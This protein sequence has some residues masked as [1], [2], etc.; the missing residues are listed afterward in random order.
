LIQLSTRSLRSP[1]NFNLHPKLKRF[2]EKRR[3]LIKGSAQAD[4]A[5]AESLAFGTLLY[6][7]TPVRL[8]GQ[9]SVR[10]TFSQRHLALTDI[11]NGSVYIPLNHISSEQAPLEALDSLLS[12]AAVLGFEYGYSTVDPLALVLWEAQFGDFANVA[13]A[14]IDNFIAVS[15]EKWQLRN[16]IVLLLPHGYEG[17]GPEHSSARIER[18]LTLCAQDNLQVC[19]ITT[20]AQYF[21]LLRRQIKNEVKSPLI[22]FTPKSILRLPEAGS[23]RS[24]FTSGAFLEIIDDEI[25][26]KDSVKRII[27]TGG[28]LYYELIKHRKQSNVNDT[29]IIRIEQLYPY[30]SDML[31]EILSSYTASKK[32]IWVQEEP[33]NMGAWNFL[34]SRLVGDLPVNCLLYYSGRPERASPAVGSS[35][36]SGL[37]QAELIQNS[38]TI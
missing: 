14:M 20:P 6:E 3:E 21:H 23:P 35:R 22:I 5:F 26:L 10:G 28:K 11:H 16:S 24:Q 37:Q 25:L 9:D 1:E 31:K 18:F 12:E 27:L 29:A 36:I 13:Q 32:V 19:C 38:F 34:S 30:R 33:K 8:S 7:G 17:Q 4:W 2:L 15:F